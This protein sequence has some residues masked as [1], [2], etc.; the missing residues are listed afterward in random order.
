MLD[1]A[2]LDADTQ[3]SDPDA[4][5]DARPISDGSTM[6]AGSPLRDA[7][8]GTVAC[9]APPD[10]TSMGP[11]NTG[12]CKASACRDAAG[13]TVTLTQPGGFYIGALWWTLVA[14][15]QEHPEAG[16]VEQGLYFTLTEDAFADLP[17]GSPLAAYYGPTPVGQPTGQVGTYRGAPCGVLDK[18]A[19]TVCAG[20]LHR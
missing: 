15:E 12:M 2:V 17:E 10:L 3:L 19:V 8:E 1:G 20:A 9:P 16:Y 14:C 6:D 18:A 5:R 13:V 4:G 11:P 7:A